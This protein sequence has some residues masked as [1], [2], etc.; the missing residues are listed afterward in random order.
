MSVRGVFEYSIIS[1]NL[2]CSMRSTILPASSPFR[3]FWRLCNW[4]PRLDHRRV[5]AAEYRKA[6]RTL[7]SSEMRSLIA[8]SFFVP[9]LETS[10][11]EC[12][13]SWMSGGRSGVR[14]RASTVAAW[15][16][17][18]LNPLDSR[19]ANVFSRWVGLHPAIADA[20]FVRISDTSATKSIACSIAPTFTGMPVSLILKSTKNAFFSTGGKGGSIASSCI[21]TRTS[22]R[23]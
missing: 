1:A 12:S 16:L 17:G 13:S 8:I 4:T 7:P 9:A 3:G 14:A 2:P 10:T 15:R 21:S 11:R 20:R 23:Q 5:D 22:C 19:N 6:P 18:I